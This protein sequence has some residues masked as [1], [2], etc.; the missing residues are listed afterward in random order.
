VAE[1][2]RNTGGL[3]FDFK[4]KKNTLR[5]LGTVQIYNSEKLDA[6]EGNCEDE[7]E[8]HDMT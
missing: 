4:T 2:L 3:N 5:H 1:K 8:A 6:P 7:R